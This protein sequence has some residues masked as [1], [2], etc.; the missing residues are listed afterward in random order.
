MIGFIKL[1]NFNISLKMIISIKYFNK[2]TFFLIQKIITAEN[3]PSG[4]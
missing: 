4:V 2:N 1:L 3:F